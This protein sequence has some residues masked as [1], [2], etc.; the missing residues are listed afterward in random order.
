MPEDKY[1]KLKNIG[2]KFLKLKCKDCGNEQ[3]TY[4]KVST[5]VVCNICGSTIAKPTGGTL[6]TSAEVTEVL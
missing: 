5:E 3:I 4:S 1:V 2:N 6:K